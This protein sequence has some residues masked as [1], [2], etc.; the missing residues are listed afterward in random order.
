MVNVTRKQF[1]AAC[2]QD[3]STF[4]RRA[5]VEMEPSAYKHN[6]HIDCISAHLQEVELGNIR[7]LIVNV[8]PRTA[9]TLLA[10]IA[11]T[12]WVLG[13][14][15]GARVV[16]VSYSQR[17]SEKIAYKARLLMETEWFMALFPSCRLDANQ[18]QKAN[19]MTTAGGGRFSTSVGGVLTGEGGDYILLDDPMNPEEALSDVKRISGNEWVDSTVHTRLN[20]LETGRIVCIMQRLHSDDTTGHLMEQGGWHLLKLPAETKK[21]IDIEIAGKSWRYEGLLHEDRL[22]LETLEEL[23]NS[24]GSYTYAGQYLQEPVP[25]GGGEFKADFMQYYASKSLD[26]KSGNIYITVDPANSKKKTSD[27]TAMAV[28]LLGRDQNYYLID[29]VRERLNPTERIERLFALHRK[30]NQLSGKPPKVGYERYGMM[31]DTHYIQKKQT[32]ESYR[33]PLQ[34]IH[35]GVQKEERIRRLIPVMER[36]QIWLPNDLFYTDGKGLPQNLMHDIVSEEF[37]LFPF[38]RHDDFADAMSMLFD[39]NPIFPKMG[40]V[41]KESDWGLTNE[42]FSILDL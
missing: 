21:P 9:K 40:D 28:W 37:L 2:R 27:F 13:R 11:F 29:G 1:D 23:Q 33:F 17:L 16:G 8:P 36:G 7:K 10:N 42:S 5:W 14:K 34:E 4:F 39:M 18:S 30:W 12:A 25:L 32:E 35:S 6:W 26:P 20:D 22:S 15:P 41:E 19:F 31:A 38:G 3:F 24:M